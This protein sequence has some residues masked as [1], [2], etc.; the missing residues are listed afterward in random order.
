MVKG[1][2]RIGGADIGA[3]VRAE[4]TDIGHGVGRARQEDVPHPGE[5][6]CTGG[7]GSLVE[8]FDHRKLDACDD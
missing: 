2:V 5:E 1:V 7:L 4:F 8:H 6:P 3:E